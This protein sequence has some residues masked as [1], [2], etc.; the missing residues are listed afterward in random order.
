MLSV[1]LL[2]LH[3]TFLLGSRKNDI[4]AAACLGAAVLLHYFLFTTLKYD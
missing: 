2:L 1:A 4:A 3:V